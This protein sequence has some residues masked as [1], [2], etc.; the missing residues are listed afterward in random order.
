MDHQAKMHAAFDLVKSK[1]DW[2][3]P[4]AKVVAGFELAAAGVTIEDVK[5]AVAFFTAT[6][7]DVVPTTVLAHHKDG[8]VCF[9]APAF[10]V[11]AA[12]YRAGPAG[13]H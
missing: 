5:E 13:D 9:E 3:K 7:A 12:G 4:I 8:M 1:S 10:L 2:K 6:E 11:N